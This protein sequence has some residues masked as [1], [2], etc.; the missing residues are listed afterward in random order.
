MLNF[1]KKNFLSSK[2]VRLFVAMFRFVSF[3]FVLFSRFSPLDV[4]LDIQ[5]FEL[6][7]LVQ[8]QRHILVARMTF[9]AGS[10]SYQLTPIAFL[11]LE[12][13]K[14]SLTVTGLL[15]NFRGLR[16]ITRF[17]ETQTIV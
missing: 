9:K 16:R 3:C 10:Q 15:D 6:P 12:A 11:K 8:H 7:L 5:L 17:Q 14:S 4:F 13:M 2:K 1:F